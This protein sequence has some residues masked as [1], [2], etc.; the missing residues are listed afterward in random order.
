MKNPCKECLL[1]N[2]C[3]AICETKK[4]FRTLLENGIKNFTNNAKT[5]SDRDRKLQREWIELLTETNIE[6]GNIIF[7]GTS[8]KSNSS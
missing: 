5:L 8:I 3:T 7:R 4:N 6:M 1:I 2:N